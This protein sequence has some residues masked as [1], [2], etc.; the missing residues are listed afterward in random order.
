MWGKLCGFIHYIVKICD[1]YHTAH[2]LIILEFG[3]SLTLIWHNACLKLMSKCNINIICATNEHHIWTNEHPLYWMKP[4]S[5]PYM[6][7]ARLESAISIRNNHILL[8]CL[9]GASICFSHAICLQLVVPC[10]IPAL[11]GC[12]LNIFF[13]LSSTSPHYVFF[14]IL[15]DLLFSARPLV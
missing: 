15:E 13:W 10:L 2:V 11:K 7:V 5:P 4:Q 14:L 8:Q 6:V 9:L 3:I 1:V 12:F